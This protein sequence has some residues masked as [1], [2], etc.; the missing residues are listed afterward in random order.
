MVRLLAPLTWGEKQNRWE[1]RLA[2]DDYPG[3]WECS[4]MNNGE[5]WR[6]WRF[7]VENRRPKIHPEQRENIHLNYNSYL[8]DMEIPAGGSALDKRLAGASTS[9]FYGQN[10]KSAE[11]KSM[12]GKVPTKGNP[13]PVASSSPSAVKQ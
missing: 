12:A 11:G 10:W 4:L 3:N 13:F 5:I 1:Q 8:V 7:V 9:L 2:L 6:T